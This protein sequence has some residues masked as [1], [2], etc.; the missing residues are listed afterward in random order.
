MNY[1]AH[2]YLARD[3]DELLVGNFI[4]DF[5]KGKLKDRYP[6]KIARGI[7]LHRKI[8]AYT[9]SHPVL[10]D[11]RSLISSKRRRF[12]GVIIDVFFDHFLNVNWTRY[13]TVPLDEFIR[14]VCD[15]ISQY[16]E[17]LPARAKK[18]IPAIRDGNWLGRYRNINDLGD[19]FEGL[20][21][22]ISRR[23]QLPGSERELLDNYSEFERY[24]NI[25]FPQLIDYAESVKKQI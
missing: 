14:N 17:F 20:S 13:S 11:C 18:L 23:N 19:V 7:I 3:S 15:V 2:L 24:F 8:D 22:R 6:P 21:R 16:D 9:D 1:L 4:G 5:V 25:F 10:R 12:S